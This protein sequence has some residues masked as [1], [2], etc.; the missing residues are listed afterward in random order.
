MRN[1]TKVIAGF[2][3]GITTAGGIATASGVFST[4]V[5]KACVDKKT[6][7]IYAAV[8]NTCPANR[9]GVN[10]GSLSS[11]AGS[12]NSI[13]NKVSPSV[14]TIMSQH[15]MG[16]VVAQVRYLKLHQLLVMLL[17]IIT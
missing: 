14:V 10:L 2:L 9:T 4:T 6:Q 3:L 5:V 1:S 17:P 16:A 11:V 13:V 15:Q 12:L 7:A 8:N